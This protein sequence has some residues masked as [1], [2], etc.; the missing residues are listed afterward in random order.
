ML[1]LTLTPTLRYYAADRAHPLRRCLQDQVPDGAV[2]P[3]HPTGPRPL[4]QTRARRVYHQDGAATHDAA[5]VNRSDFS[6]PCK[7][8]EP[9]RCATALCRLMG[10][11]PTVGKL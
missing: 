9:A 10:G 11:V 1:A 8:S 6:Y 7:R 5:A 2:Q 3:A 4:L